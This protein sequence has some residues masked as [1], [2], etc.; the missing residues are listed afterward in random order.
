MCK[1]KTNWSLKKPR[2]SYGDVVAGNNLPDV[3][4]DLR[5]F[6]GINL[7]MSALRAAATR[8]L[9]GSTAEGEGGGEA[10]DDGA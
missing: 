5:A 1:R 10:S 9:E 3:D 8:Q 7:N 4:S 2:V 6:S